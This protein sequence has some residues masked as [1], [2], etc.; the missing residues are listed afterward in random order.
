M[1][2]DV[3]NFYVT[4]KKP[5]EEKTNFSFEYQDSVTNLPYK[6]EL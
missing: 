5:L 3:V 1:K 4:F 2:N 6:S